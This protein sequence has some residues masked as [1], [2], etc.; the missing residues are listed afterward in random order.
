MIGAIAASGSLTL[1]QL[2]RQAGFS[3]LYRAVL[4]A[5]VA[6]RNSCV[7]MDNLPA[8]KA[9]GIK[10][11]IEAAGAVFGLPVSLLP[12]FQSHRKRYFSQRNFRAKAA[13]LLNLGQLLRSLSSTMPPKCHRLV[14]LTAVK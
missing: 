3:C 1:H 11:A 13:L 14:L 10:A 12:I 2:G 9:A 8:H 5:P 7:V 4:N 6:S